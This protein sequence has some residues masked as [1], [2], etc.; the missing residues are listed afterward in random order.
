MSFSTN[1]CHLLRQ[2]DVSN[3]RLA[4][5]IGVSQTTVAG[6]KAGKF[7][8][9]EE[10]LGKIA[11]FFGVSVDFM[12]GLDE[13]PE[14]QIPHE[15]LR[16]VIADDGIQIYLDDASNKMSDEDWEEVLEFIRFKQRRYGH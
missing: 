9:S 15:N 12:M 11:D 14:P 4:K 6:W 10:T 2:N 1:L 7:P 3:Y 13:P 8:Q 16:R 5:A